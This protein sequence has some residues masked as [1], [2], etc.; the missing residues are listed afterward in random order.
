MKLSTV[1]SYALVGVQAQLIHIEVH[2]ANGLPGLSIVGL[3]EA[4]VRESKDRVR[5]AIQNAGFDYPARRITV[6][7]A[8]ADL[9]KFGAGYDLA[10]AIGILHASDQLLNADLANHAFIGELSLS[11]QIRP[12][13]G[14]LPIAVTSYSQ[15]KKLIAPADNAGEIQIL[16]RQENLLAG[17]LLSV[18]AHLCR[19]KPLP[20]IKLKPSAKNSEVL[21]LSEVQ[22][23]QQAKRVLE[24][25]AAGNHSLLMQ[26]PPGT[27]KTML[28]SRLPGII[29]KL[30]P[31]ES[32]EVASI[33]SVADV[34][35]GQI[36]QAPFR[37]PH[38]TAS[39]VALV[40][41]GSRPTPG[42]ISLAHR[43]I[44]FL[45]ELPE[46]PRKVLEVMRQPMES[47]E[48]SVSRAAI[49]TTFPSDFQL[50]AAMNPC[51]CGHAGEPR[52]NCTPDLINRYQ[53]RV[54][55]PLLDRIDMQIRLNRSTYE[56]T[57]ANIPSGE[58]SNVIRERVIQARE[59]QL[60]RQGKLNSSLT[61]SEAQR[62]ISQNKDIHEITKT[63]VARMDLSMRALHKVIKVALTIADLASRP[64]KKQDVLE[65]VSYREQAQHRIS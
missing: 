49:K 58:S 35:R 13:R 27:G 1:F 55:G 22:G 47:G 9:P 23:Q 33:Y 56:L 37:S 21:C 5:S 30:R 2:I 25:A 7:L 41:G 48:I 43:G 17:T 57:E 65:A 29:P 20:Q 11:G 45:D 28:A 39:P 8:P 14:I 64:I 24:I 53:S 61:P 51:P 10:I 36:D 4:S 46:F 15:G 26:G 18:C 63:I 16:E 6:N 60:Q 38:H 34:A 3:P 32:I 59:R 54:S 40:G 50:V 12:V 31:E 19:E 62:T 44:L 52:C 42:E